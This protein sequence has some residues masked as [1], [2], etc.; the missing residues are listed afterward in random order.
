VTERLAD[1]L[2]RSLLTEGRDLESKKGPLALSSTGN[3]HV[4]FQK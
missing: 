3:D 2:A 1:T 4:G